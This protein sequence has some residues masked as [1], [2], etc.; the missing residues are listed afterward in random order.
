MPGVTFHQQLVWGRLLGELMAEVLGSRECQPQQIIPVPLHCAR[1]RQRGFNQALELARPIARALA[2]PV[3][4]HSCRRMNNTAMQSLL[5]FRQRYA[6]VR[7][8]F[9]VLGEVAEHVAII[10]DVMT[11]GHTVNE[12][13]RALRQAGVKRIEVWCCARAGQ[14]H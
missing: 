8:A 4:F 6:N 2:L 14:S 7:Q 13:S 5:P 9:T 10:D 12:L 11:S 1:L 3:N